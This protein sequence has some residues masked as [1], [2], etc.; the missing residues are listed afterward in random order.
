MKALSTEQQEELQELITVLSDLDLPQLTLDQK[1][2]LEYWSVE[3]KAK[4]LRRNPKE[5]VQ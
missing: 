5:E 2:S 4:R 1:G 3:L